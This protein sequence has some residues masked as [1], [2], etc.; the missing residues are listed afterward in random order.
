M[1]DSGPRSDSDPTQLTP[2]YPSAHRSKVVT[3]VRE[4]DHPRQLGPYRIE[5]VIGEGGMGTVYKAEQLSPIRRTVAVKVVK[6]G[7]DTREVIAR[8]ESE[9]QALAMMNHSNVAKVLD[10]GAT[11]TGRPYFVMEFVAGE[12][13]TAYADRHK[14][15]VRARLELF[16]QACDAV[17]HA[18]QKAIIHRDL[19]PTNILVSSEGD[20]PVVKVIDFG[21]A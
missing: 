1:S 20:K 19:K 2:Q 6:L 15:T 21:V 18:H 7:M 8:F 14:L 16:T 17:Q 10:A 3:A 13:I 9:R 11:E 4:L 5:Q 12:P